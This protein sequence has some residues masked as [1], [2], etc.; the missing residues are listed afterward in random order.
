MSTGRKA[1]NTVELWLT[2]SAFHT[3]TRP[4][5]LKEHRQV[6]VST[7]HKLSNSAIRAGPG[8]SSDLQGI[9]EELGYV[10]FPYPNAA[11]WF[12]YKGGLFRV[13]LQC[14]GPP[15]PKMENDQNGQN[16]THLRPRGIPDAHDDS[17]FVIR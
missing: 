3:V 5:M 15:P 16:D 1:H 14:Y 6:Q 9:R 17:D 7:G 4:S 11:T 8:E 2:G 10:G 13:K 12:T